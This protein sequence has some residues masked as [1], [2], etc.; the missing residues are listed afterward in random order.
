MEFATVLAIDRQQRVEKIGEETVLVHGLIENLNTI[1]HKN[2]EIID[3]IDS[4]VTRVNA[5]VKS[6]YGK[7]TN[8]DNHLRSQRQ[9][10]CCLTLCLSFA[11]IV[12]VLFIIL[13]LRP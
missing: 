13:V 3:T 4:V 12:F 1:V 9:H 10:A 7:L 11:V 5:D 2:S 6:A 8:A